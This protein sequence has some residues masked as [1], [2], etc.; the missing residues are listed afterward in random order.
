[1]NAMLLGELSE[2]VNLV[3]DA[4]IDGKHRIIYPQ[5]FTPRMFL[6]ALK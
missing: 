3:I 2:D 4:I 1:M 6:D 5:L